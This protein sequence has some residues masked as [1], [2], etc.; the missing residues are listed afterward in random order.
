MLCKVSEGKIGNGF[1]WVYD[2]EYKENDIEGSDLDSDFE[3]T[4]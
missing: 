3:E 1:M 2:T 4:E